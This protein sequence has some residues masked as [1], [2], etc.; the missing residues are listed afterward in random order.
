MRMML[1]WSVPVEKGNQMLKDGSMKAMIESTMEMLKPEASYFLP[2]HGLR[3][4]MIFFDMKDTSDIPR[5]VEKLFQS[6]NA[7]VEVLP[8]MNAEDLKKGLAAL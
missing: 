3:S 8:V 1:R 7:A 6:G 4:G 5:I 2:D